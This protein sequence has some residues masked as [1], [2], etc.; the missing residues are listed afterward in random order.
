MKINGFISHLPVR[1]WEIKDKRPKL[2]SK[3]QINDFENRNT[4]LINKLK[5]GCFGK[6]LDYH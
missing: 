3:N 4:E 6:R 2:I 1:K 5:G